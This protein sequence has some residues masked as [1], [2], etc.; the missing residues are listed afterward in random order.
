MF[1]IQKRMKAMEE[2]L[3]KLMVYVPK[4]YQLLVNAK[5]AY[6][7]E[8]YRRDVC[9]KCSNTSCVHHQE[10]TL[11]AAAENIMD[12]FI[13][14]E[15]GAECQRSD[16]SSVEKMEQNNEKGHSEVDL[17]IILDRGW[18]CIVSCTVGAFWGIIISILMKSL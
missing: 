9:A 10:T 7:C 3:D 18:R 12:D 2:R 15:K 17:Y 13:K 5:P 14:A 1:K 11:E 4:L 16:M 6:P 8:Q